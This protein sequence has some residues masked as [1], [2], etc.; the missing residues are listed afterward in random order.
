MSL[1]QSPFVDCVLQRS[2]STMTTT[3]T[4]NTTIALEFIPLFE[5]E[6][7]QPAVVTIV[8]Q[9]RLSLKCKLDDYGGPTYD[10]CD[11]EDNDVFA[12]L[13]SIRMRKDEP[14]TVNSSFDSHPHPT[15]TI[16]TVTA[17]T[18]ATTVEFCSRVSDAQL[19]TDLAESTQ[20]ASSCLQF[21]IRMISE[22]KSRVRLVK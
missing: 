11:D 10:D 18:I 22:S 15:A 3:T 8:D 7:E 21:F 4:A 5:E 2:G 12:E 1:V 16:A 19:A 9:P 14:N 17:T 6:E 13:V 20:S